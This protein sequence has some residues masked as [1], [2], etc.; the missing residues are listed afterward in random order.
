MTTQMIRNALI[1]PHKMI[2]KVKVIWL[3]HHT[4]IVQPINLRHCQV[5]PKHIT[6]LLIILYLNHNLASLI[7]KNRLTRIRLVRK[8][9]IIQN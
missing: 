8:L 1:A 4:I 5:L 7:I 9:I 2:K 6:Y 3:V